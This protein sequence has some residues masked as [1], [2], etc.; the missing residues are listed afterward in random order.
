MPDL[1]DLDP[2]PL[3]DLMEIGA[4]EGLVQELIVLYQE[5]IPGRV[6]LLQKAIE[7]G[8]L[9]RTMAE[10]HGLKGALGNLGLLRFARL[11]EQIETEAQGGRLDAALPMSGHLQA[12]YE[13]GLGAL[14][15]TFEPT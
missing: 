14:V 2:Q 6:A 5:D 9:R 15:A 8:D 3:R 4:T 11:V 12:A 7:G 10:A 13:A 1:P